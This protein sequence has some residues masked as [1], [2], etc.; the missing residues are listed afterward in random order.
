MRKKRNLQ[1]LETLA[2][3]R[4]SRWQRHVSGQLKSL[5]AEEQRLRQLH[6]YVDEYKAPLTEQSASQSIM[7]MRSQRL[8]VDRLRQA[9]DQQT[10]HVANKREAAEKGIR[11]WKQERSKRLAIQKFSERQEQEAER[12]RERRSQAQLDEIGRNAFLRRSD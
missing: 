10:V 7:H 8:F 11:R 6:T 9:V 2:Q 12:Q 4:E 3:G 1:S 5:Q